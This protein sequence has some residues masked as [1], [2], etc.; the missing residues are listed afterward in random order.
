MGDDVIDGDG[1]VLVFSNAAT[2][3]VEDN[4]GVGA[5]ADAAVVDVA[6]VDGA[7]VLANE[8][9]VAVDVELVPFVVAA[10]G[11]VDDTTT[12]VLVEVEGDPFVIGFEE[13]ETAAAYRIGGKAGFD[14]RCPWCT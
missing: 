13:L 4:V 9:N 7:G 3:A 11:D 14:P 6:A 1:G 12:G 10:G 2:D 5:V 8:G